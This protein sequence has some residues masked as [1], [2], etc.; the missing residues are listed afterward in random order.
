[1][2]PFKEEVWGTWRVD[3][4]DERKKMVCFQIPCDILYI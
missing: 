3:G 4:K 2:L 1:M